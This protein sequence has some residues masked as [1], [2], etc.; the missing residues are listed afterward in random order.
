[1]NPETNK[2]GFKAHNLGRDTRQCNGTISCFIVSFE[3]KIL[4]KLI[5]FFA[6]Q[7]T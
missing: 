4:M 6:K 3:C 2:L 1:M 5:H 7:M